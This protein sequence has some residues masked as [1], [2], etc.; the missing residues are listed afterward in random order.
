MSTIKNEANDVCHSIGSVWTNVL[1]TTNVK[2]QWDFCL[3]HDKVILTDMYIKRSTKRKNSGTSTYIQSSPYWTSSLVNSTSIIS[4][5]HQ[6]K[7]LLTNMYYQQVNR[8]KEAIETSTSVQ[9]MRPGH[10]VKLHPHFHCHWYL[11][12]LMCHE[13]GQSA[14][15]HTQL[16]LSTTLDHILFNISWH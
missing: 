5:K 7:V 16:Y 6:N 9:I 2:K 12:V 8:K 11:F 13:A 15:L 3:H 1:K 4:V 14:F 10:D